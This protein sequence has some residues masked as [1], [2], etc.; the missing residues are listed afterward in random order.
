[1]KIRIFIVDDHTI[2]RDGLKTLLSLRSDIE[3]VGEAASGLDALQKIDEL[4]PNLVLMDICMPGLDGIEIC[5]RI[6]QRYK[7]V[8]VIMLSQYEEKEDVLEAIRA[9]AKGFVS[10]RA[11]STELIQAIK[12]VAQGGA[13]FSPHVAKLILDECRDTRKEGFTSEILTPREMEILKLIGEG[14]SDREIAE[15]LFLSPRTVETHK[16]K[17][18]EKLNVK[19]K[20]ELVKYAIKKGIIKL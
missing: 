13:Y 5:R 8:K 11:A 1:M 3:V 4:K 6:T 14:Y 15:M 10:K 17:I 19:K 2:V 7:D 18:M 16:V 20:I 12:A 9:G